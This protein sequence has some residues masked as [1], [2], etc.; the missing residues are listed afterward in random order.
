MTLE[1]SPNKKVKD[2]LDC[3]YHHVESEN[4]D[5]FIDHMSK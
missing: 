4:I 1:F 3:H 5:G 2:F